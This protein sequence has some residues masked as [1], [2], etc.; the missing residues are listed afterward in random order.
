[1]SIKMQ[2]DEH[3]AE[4]YEAIKIL[5]ELGFADEEIQEKY[6]M[7]KQIDKRSESIDK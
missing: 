3:L 6:E 4:D 7:Q 1:M 2:L 5:R